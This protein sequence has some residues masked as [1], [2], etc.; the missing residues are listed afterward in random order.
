MRAAGQAN[1]IQPHSDAD[2][3]SANALQIITSNTA[4][5]CGRNRQIPVL[6]L[7]PACSGFEVNRR[8]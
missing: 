7:R 6:H 1:A 8:R 5:A 2:A 3:N 4:C